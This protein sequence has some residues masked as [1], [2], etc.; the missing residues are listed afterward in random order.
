MTF[1][2]ENLVINSSYRN[3]NLYNII[4]FDT[5]SIRITVDEENER[6][7]FYNYDIYDGEEHYYSEDIDDF[8]KDLKFLIKK[9]NRITLFAHNI[10]HDLR[11]LRILKD[12]IKDEFIGLTNSS[13]LL[14]KI[15]YL[16]F[17]G[18]HSRHII[19]QFIDSY[20][21][22]NTKVEMLGKMVGF[23]KVNVEEYNYDAEDWNKTLKIDGEERVKA[24]TEILY[25]ALK[26]FID[27]NYAFSMSIA[28]TS[29]NELKKT[30]PCSI[31]IPKLFIP[32]TLDLY[33]G[34]AV[35]PY[36]LVHKKPLKVIDINSLYPWAMKKH[37]Y[38]VKLKG[39]I[40]DYRW[41]EDDI[42]NNNYNYIIKCKYYSNNEDNFSPIYSKF[43]NLLI[44]FLEN[45]LWITGR[46]YLYLIYN[47][48]NV[49]IED[50][51]AFHNADIFSSFVDKFYNKRLAATNE[52]EKYFYKIV[53]NSAYG[54][55]GQHKSFSEVIPFDEI[56]NPIIK[57]II[58]D[59]QG[60][61]VLID[62]TFYNIYDEFVTIIKEAEPK[63]NPLIAAEITANARLINYDYSKLIGFNNLYYTDTDSFFTD[64]DMS[65]FIG[66]E[67]G[68]VKIEKAG[69]FNIYGSKDYSYYGYC[70]KKS[71]KICNGGTTKGE[72]YVIKGVNTIP[73]G[74]TYVNSHWSKLRFNTS[75]D[76]YIHKVVQHLKRI[77]KKMYYTDGGIGRE[78]FN[79]KEYKLYMSK[80]NVKESIVKSIEYR[81]PE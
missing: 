4:T 56:N 72:H 54:K 3:F 10:I 42:K 64:N 11:T 45:N 77:N 41:L 73:E 33:R 14:D 60:S 80:D 35:M 20:N 9:Y 48:F 71:C 51:F 78:W 1:L 70:D 6:L 15:I 50:V 13:K 29:F 16:K 52:Y 75:D 62:D 37:L 21:Y 81:S 36:K 30:L 2:D 47:N 23:N 79:S 12:V 38:S 43:D 76:V 19:L 17:Q 49:M 44:P 27:M 59:Y 69:I 40:T 32:I 55:F 67:L 31:T 53:L 24:D 57:E 28:G 65:N 61:R 74:N 66:N 63:F 34:S 68:Q 5:E 22:F 7:E 8:I 58:L 25:L 39:H 26:Y 18:K 46:E